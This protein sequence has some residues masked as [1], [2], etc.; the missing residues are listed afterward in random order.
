MA[1]PGVDEIGEYLWPRQTCMTSR[2]MYDIV[3][4]A[5]SRQNVKLM[6]MYDTDDA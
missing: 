2:Q 5:T 4:H 6:H 1:M 3:D